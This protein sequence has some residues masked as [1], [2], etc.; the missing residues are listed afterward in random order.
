MTFKQVLEAILASLVAESNELPTDSILT[1]F[2][3]LEN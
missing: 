3:S 2:N 1:M